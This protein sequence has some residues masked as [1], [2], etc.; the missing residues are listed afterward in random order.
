MWPS[1]WRL[2][3]HRERPNHVLQ[4]TAVNS[5]HADEIHRSKDKR[6]VD[7]IRDV[8]LFGRLWYGE[9]NS[10]SN[11]IA[12]ALHYSRSHDAVIRLYDAAGNVIETR[13]HA[14]RARGRFQ[15][16]VAALL[17]VHDRLRRRFAQFKLCV[18]LL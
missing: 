4:P 15:R 1:A 11:A 3:M 16:A 17:I 12:Y 10:V 6:G 18:H 7:L 5:M 8:L 2:D 9:P 14:T 13:E